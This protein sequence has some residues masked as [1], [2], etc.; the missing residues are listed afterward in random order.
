MN[1][2]LMLPAFLYGGPQWS[3]KIL[4]ISKQFEYNLCMRHQ[5]GIIPIYT[6]TV[7]TNA[8][9]YNEI[10]LYTQRTSACFSQPCGNLITI[11]QYEY[12]F[13]NDLFL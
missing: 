9:R 13:L 12:I 1:M 8:L 3:V 10:S 5:P 11:L 7:P 6:I 4:L 2:V